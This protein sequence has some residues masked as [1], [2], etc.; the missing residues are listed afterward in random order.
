M[1]FTWQVVGAYA[2]PTRL[3][4]LDRIFLDP[5]DLSLNMD[6][7]GFERLGGWPAGDFPVGNVKT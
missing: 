2:Q 1:T 4:A 7:I 6:G 5:A 3:P